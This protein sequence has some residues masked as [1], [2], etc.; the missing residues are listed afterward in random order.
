MCES[1]EVYHGPISTD[2][3]PK[4]PLNKYRKLLYLFRTHHKDEKL[5]IQNAEP[6]KAKKTSKKKEDAKKKTNCDER[7]EIFKKNMENSWVELPN[8]LKRK[9]EKISQERLSEYLDED[10]DQCSM[11]SMPSDKFLN[12]NKEPL[13]GGFPDISPY[14]RNSP[15]GFRNTCERFRDP[16]GSTSSNEKS[17]DS[18]SDTYASQSVIFETHPIVHYH[19]S[20]EDKVSRIDQVISNGSGFQEVNQSFDLQP[21]KKQERVDS[22]SSDSVINDSLMSSSAS[23]ASQNDDSGTEI[24]SGEVSKKPLKEMVSDFEKICTQN[25]KKSQFQPKREKKEDSESQSSE[26]EPK[27]QYSDILFDVHPNNE[28]MFVNNEFDDKERPKPP[29]VYQELSFEKEKENETYDEVGETEKPKHIYQELT[30]KEE[31]PDVLRTSHLNAE[32][33]AKKKSAEAIAKE[34]SMQILAKK[35]GRNPKTFDK[36]REEF[37][38]SLGYDISVMKTDGSIVDSVKKTVI[39]LEPPEVVENYYSVSN[40]LDGPGI[41]EHPAEDETS[42]TFSGDLQYFSVAEWRKAVAMGTK[43]GIASVAMETIVEEPETDTATKLTVREILRRFEE[44]GN[45]HFNEKLFLSEEEK[46]ATLKQ[47]HET[48]KCLEEK[49]RLFETKH[50]LTHQVRSSLF[51]FFFQKEGIFFIGSSSITI[52][53]M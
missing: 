29:I 49:V 28:G 9:K 34:L 24:G 2:E 40:L 48:L 3:T 20:Q 30:H 31:E 11:K 44:L 46:T 23:E 15:E 38:K 32:E 21:E 14:L 42:S 17:Y 52:S 19:E 5:K 53:L 35:G 13:N 27:H 4:P 36:H 51:T 37:L 1:R 39:A 6:K 45:K 22:N 43:R 33:K 16:S 25:L 10:T 50:D 7:K 8:T 26:P 18:K 41:A 12:R 47:I